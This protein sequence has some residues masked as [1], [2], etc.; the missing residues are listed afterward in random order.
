MT[1]PQP[2]HLPPVQESSLREANGQ[3]LYQLLLSLP[4]RLRP[5]LSFD[6]MSLVLKKEG[7]AKKLWYVLDDRDPSVLTLSPS[8]PSQEPIVSWI[9]EHGDTAVINFEEETAFCNGQDLSQQR[10]LKS[11]CAVPLATAHRKVGAVLIGSAQ[12]AAYTQEHA[13]TLAAVVD[14][15]SIAIDNLF[16][17]AE[18]RHYKALSDLALSLASCA[19]ENLSG[20]LATILFPLLDFDFLDVLVFKE[21]SSEVRCHSIGAGRFPPPDV[22][23]E[24]TTIW[25]VYQQQQ[26]LCIADWKR[27]N[28]FAV[29][30]EALKKLG[31]E[32]RSL[33]RVPLR[34]PHWNLGVFSVASSRPHDYSPEE[35]R[36][37][38]LVADQVAL[39]IANTL[40][41][42][43]ARRAQSV[44]EAKSAQLRMLLDLTSSLAAM[45]ELEEVLKKVTMGTRRIMRSDLAI[46]V[47]L[48]REI[49]Q[50]RVKAFDFSEDAA[51]DD[52][53]LNSLGKT[54][55]GLASSTGK[56]WTCSTDD[57]AR[58]GVAAHPQWIAAGFRHCCVMPLSNRDR[59]PG[60]LILSK[61]ED[62]GYTQ[63]E[64]DFLAQVCNQVAIAVYGALVHGERASLEEEIHNDMFDEIVGRSAPLERVLR[65]VEIVAPTDAG[66]L[67]QGETGT[68]KELIARA[69]HNLSARRDRPFVK[70]NCA[71]I[72]SGLLE[73]E[74]FGH[75]KGA[76]TGAVTRK[77]GR[78]EVANQ[79]TLFLDEVGDIPLELQPKLLRVLQEQEFERLGSTQTQRV[80]V[81]IVAATHRNLKRM[82]EEGQFRSDLFYRLH[83]FP[84]SIP[85]LRNRREDIP[86][87]VRHYVDKYSKRMNRCIEAI[88]PQAMEAFENYSW[89]GNVRELQTFIQRAVILSPGAVL[90]APIAELTQAIA[91]APAPKLESLEKAERDRLLKVIR[92]CNW[93]IGGPNG[94]AARL[95]MKRTTLAYRIRKL[96]IPCRPD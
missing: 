16:S 61:R 1:G 95:G 32:Y 22:P 57:L 51:L 21:G 29:R 25:W 27:D 17:H 48:D 55:G 45:P 88:P 75:E 26:P 31:F 23:M 8:P 10:P 70:L 37:L 69:I 85:P 86:I 43:S 93:V 14:P 54:F 33:C 66:V 76:F 83:A 6:R 79:G 96:N 5:Y 59:V 82:V 49:G 89:P 19:P 67:I 34:T 30:R 74:L 7:E 53:A 2:R 50:L 18:L 81:R 71:A 64:V 60:L 72:P 4:S 24:Q 52:E 84:L 41:L 56:A 11:V 35:V 38:S 73:S 20:N 44:L 58:N 28:R 77:A 63:D 36:F 78:F 94:A 40:N 80:D 87:L 65:E 90:R 47:L 15:L 9:L 46:M 62:A 12:R 68:G 92:E 3:R 42:E 91:V 13:D 39:A